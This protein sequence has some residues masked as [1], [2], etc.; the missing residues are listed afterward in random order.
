MFLKPAPIIPP[1]KLNFDLDV[2]SSR[3][4]NVLKG[5]PLVFYL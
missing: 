2:N 1:F 3:E 4:K 5:A